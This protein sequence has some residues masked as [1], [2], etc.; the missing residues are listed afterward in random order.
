MA[1][2]T[3]E[4]STTFFHWKSMS[5]KTRANKRTTA[6]NQARTAPTFTSLSPPTNIA[7]G[8]MLR[9]F[10]IFVQANTSHTISAIKAHTLIGQFNCFHCSIVQHTIVISKLLFSIVQCSH[11]HFT[12]SPYQLQRVVCYI[13]THRRQQLGFGSGSLFA[14]SPCPP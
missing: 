13:F 4:P 12:A 11:F 10:S 5:M 8:G 2:T 14:L 1:S 9:T 7:G 3:F 6:A